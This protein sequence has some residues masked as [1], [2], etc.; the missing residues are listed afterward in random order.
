LAWEIS[1]QDNPKNIASDRGKPV[2]KKDGVL[3]HIFGAAMPMK[4]I[5]G[6]ACIFARQEQGRRQTEH[7][8]PMG[9]SHGG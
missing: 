4:T 5:R 9:K 3:R 2:I 1:S 7:R 6:M 8:P